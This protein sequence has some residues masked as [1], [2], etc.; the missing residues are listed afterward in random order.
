M[1]NDTMTF[2]HATFV[3][4]TF[5]YICNNSVTND[6]ILIKL[7]SLLS[8]NIFNRC[9]YPFNLDNLGQ[10]SYGLLSM[11]HLSMQNLFW[12]HLSW[13]YLY[14]STLSQLLLT[15]F[16]PNFKVSFLGPSIAYVNNC[17]GDICPV[18]IQPGNISPYQLYLRC[19][20]INFE[21]NFFY[22]NFFLPNFFL[23]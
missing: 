1:S 14:I 17:H 22:P 16:W 6:L 20:W 12:Q 4:A 9:Y 11:Q 21:Q 7:Q 10:L 8:G 5:V 18:K 23:D 3:L 19:Y 2:V 15:R 13:Q